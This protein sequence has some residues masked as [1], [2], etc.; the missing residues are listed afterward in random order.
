MKLL[1][2]GTNVGQGSNLSLSRGLRG[3]H[4]AFNG[5]CHVVPVPRGS[6]PRSPYQNDFDAL[7]G[8]IACTSV[9]FTLSIPVLSTERTT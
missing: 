6:K 5:N 8:M 7:Y 3:F 2:T 9:E 4:P 1:D